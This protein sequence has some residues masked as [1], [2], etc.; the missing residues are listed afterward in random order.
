[1]TEQLAKVSR[2]S[3][4]PTA[5]LVGLIEADDV[6]G[7]L[8]LNAQVAAPHLRP[9]QLF[10]VRSI[11]DRW[12]K[13]AEG[14]AAEAWAKVNASAPEL[15][16]GL[17]RQRLI[18]FLE[19]QTA[20]LAKKVAERGA[21]IAAQ[22][23]AA[24]AAGPKA[25]PAAAPKE[26]EE[27]ATVAALLKELEEPKP[28]ELPKP[29]AK[30]A[31]KATSLDIPQ[32]PLPPP[33]ATEAE[34]LTYPRGLVGH[35][36]QYMI[37]TAELPDRQMALCGAL[38]VCALAIARKVLGPNNNAVALLTILIAESGA[39]KQHIINC[40]KLLLRAIGMPDVCV[41]SS[42]A[43]IQS[44]EEVLQGKP[45]HLE[46][47]PTAL[48]LN[49]E[50]GSFLNRISTQTGNVSEI[51]S[52]LQTLWGWPPQLEWEG[53]IKT[54]KDNTKVWGPAFMIFGS[55]TERAFFTALK[56]KEVASGFV[57]RH[58]LFNAGRGAIERIDAK[59]DWTQCPVWLIDAFKAIAGEPAP[60]DNRPIPRK[61]NQGKPT[62]IF[63]RDW[64]RMTW[65]G[66]AKEAW[67]HF[68]NKEIR[69]LPSADEREM[70]IRA[71]EIALRIA[72]IVAA[73]AFRGSTVVTAEDYDWA[74]R[75]SRKSCAQM[76][77]G[78]QRHMLENYEQADLVEHI[79]D[80]FRKKT[81]LRWGQ[82][83]KH[84][85]RKT[86]DYNKIDRAM[87]HLISTEEIHLLPEEGGPGRPTHR[88]RWRGADRKGK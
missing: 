30:P 13:G 14:L 16:E 50:Y 60:L 62:G 76:A 51:P 72:T 25:E 53:A 26:E 73:F 81:V 19:E 88:Y 58:L 32:A 54:G 59:Y 80:E 82:I 27:N 8:A 41:G 36:V 78:L 17:L 69:S 7:A 33:D 46:G 12:G 64:R 23:D 47:K 2:E 1:M 29:E 40:I 35:I 63:L 5:A 57:N 45:P 15:N 87:Q 83:R 28:T 6:D 44:I 42:I 48:I 75:V 70:W 85:E 84:C 10:F 38:L 22:L 31:P 65:G 55:S 86:G 66:G 9:V 21:G 18:A 74:M 52:T 56:S 61:D 24:E 79:R 71:P 67:R 43:S 49:D 3:E 39:G 4:E 77:E 11:G 68:E 20:E 34:A 37:D